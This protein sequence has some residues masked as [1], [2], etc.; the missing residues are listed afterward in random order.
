MVSWRLPVPHRGLVLLVLFGAPSK[1]IFSPM[2][3]ESPSTPAPQRGSSRRRAQRQRS[4][5]GWGQR[6]LITSGV[7]LV[8]AVVAYFGFGIW[9]ES[10][11]R[12]E[13]FQTQLSDGLA[14]KIKAKSE[15]ESLSWNDSTVRLG[16]MTS[17]GYSDAAFAK[18]TVEDIRADVKMSLWDR[19]VEVPSITIS[20]VNVQINEEG[21]LRQPYPEPEFNSGTGGGSSWL[22]NFK[23]NRITLQETHIDDFSAT[24]KSSAGEIRLQGLPLILKNGQTLDTWSIE[25]HPK[26]D[27]ATMVTN[28]GDGIKVKF[29]DLRA[30]V[31]PEQFDLIQMEGTLER[32]QPSP[33]SSDLDMETQLSLTGNLQPN[34]SPPAAEFDLHV[35]DLKL[36]SWTQADW[37]KRLS[38]LADIDAHL[39]GDPSQ[40][41]SMRLE[42][43]FSVK[44]GVL[45]GLPVLE[46]LAEQTKTK[47]FTRLELNTAKCHFYHQG[48]IWQFSKIEI[49]SRGLIRLEGY[50]NVTG[51]SVQGVLEVGVAPGRLRA[52]DGAEQ[53]VFTRMDNG[54]KWAKPAM[55]IS[56]TLDNIQE[57]LAN[58]IKNAWFD[59]QIEN[60]TDLASKAPEA[61]LE[62]GGKVMDI[63]TKVMEQGTKVAPDVLDTG[64]K[65]LQGLFGGGR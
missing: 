28:L 13:S 7:L 35:T 27:R 43:D 42:G 47:E 52:I 39:S 24:V 2:S 53:R 12:S 64:V 32:L 33:K 8:L 15:F 26:S 59:Q 9:L 36:E 31:R 50:I 61:I 62:N 10:Y 38:G 30:R 65:M 49:E 1:F 5:G 51:N 40:P 60:V 4:S 23:P 16:K 25:S 55:R 3:D 22:D 44:R 21:K 56:G 14:E 29:K 41:T 20:R 48:D 18:T 17:T 45:T 46:N 19:T 37:V 57:D 58:R 11:L 54:Y 34:A 6:L 63:G